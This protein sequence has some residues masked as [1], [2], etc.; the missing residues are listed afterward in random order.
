M[1]GS[2]PRSRRVRRAPRRVSPRR[3]GRV[4]QL[5]TVA[6]ISAPTPSA[7]GRAAQRLPHRTVGPRGGLAIAP[8]RRRLQGGPSVATTSTTSA[9]A[10]VRA[11]A[12]AARADRRRQPAR[13]M[14]HD[15]HQRPLRR[16]LDGLQQRVGAVAVEIV[17]GVDEADAPAAERR[18]EPEHAQPLAHVVDADLAEEVLLV[19]SRRG[20]AARNRDGRAR[21]AGAR[22]DALRARRG[23]APRAPPGALGSGWAS[24]K[25]ANRQASVALPMPS[26]PPISQ[27]CASRPPR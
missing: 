25:R 18:G 9:L 26:G 2:K 27:A 1:E 6:S 7:S 21:R 20:A 22:R 5:A 3:G 10:A 13:P 19:V 11:P 24:R 4:G 15:Q 12:A 17:G 16:L 23:R 14:R 8:G